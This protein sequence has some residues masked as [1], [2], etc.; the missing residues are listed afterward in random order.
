MKPR[1]ILSTLALATG[2]ALVAHAVRCAV[3]RE[4]VWC[5]ALECPTCRRAKG[6]L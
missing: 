3:R 2:L 5:G 6:L 4:D 1:L